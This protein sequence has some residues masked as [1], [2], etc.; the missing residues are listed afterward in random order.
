[1]SCENYL[2]L[3]SSFLLFLAACD[4]YKLSEK[5]GYQL[6]RNYVKQEYR[7]PMFDGI[8][9]VT[10]V[11]SP[12][13]A[14][15]TYLILLTRTPY[16]LGGFVRDFLVSLDVFFEA[17][18]IFV[19]QELRGTGRSQ[20]QFVLQRPYEPHAHV[21]R[22][23]EISF[24]SAVDASTDTYDTVEWLLN[25]IDQHNDAVGLWGPSY[26][27]WAT[28]MGMIDPHPAVKAF[29]PEASRVD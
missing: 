7:V 28:L 26:L 20:G 16:T 6:E 12:R 9:L 18:Y 29:V 3:V 10:A 5:S 11:Y 21:F 24:G 22:A 15:E 4:D 13:N 27:G 25:H 1:M 19:I 23:S 8:E 17:E 14:Q 2:A